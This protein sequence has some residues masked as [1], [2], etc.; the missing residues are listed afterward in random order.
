MLKMKKCLLLPAFNE[1]HSI[2]DTLDEFFL[3]FPD[4]YFCVIDNASTDKTYEIASKFFIENTVNGKIIKE[5]IN[6]KGKAVKRGI[7]EV[8]NEFDIFIICDSDLTYSAND[9]KKIL[10]TIINENADLV[11][12]NRMFKNT[13]KNQNKRLFHNFGNKIINKLINSLFKSNIQDTLSGFRAFNKKFKNNY[14]FLTQGFEIE[15][16]MTVFALANFYNIKEVPISYQNRP[17]GSFSKL[18]TYSDGF[19]IIAT[20][21]NL[22]RIYK[23]LP[24]FFTLALFFLLASLIIGIP[25]IINFIETNTVP[26]LPSAILA[27]LLGLISILLIMSGMILDSVSHFHRSVQSQIKN[28]WQK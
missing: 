24:F 3:H 17:Y 23:P 28:L 20:I 1:E 13:Y 26:R 10:D 27:G 4:L 19:K 15:T 2:K 22:F 9:L 11:I 6:G 18:N 25:I 8:G 7:E 21:L 12:G 16:D 14:S 5:N